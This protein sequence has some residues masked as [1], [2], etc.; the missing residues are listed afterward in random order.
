MDYEMCK[1]VKM[2]DRENKCERVSDAPAWA[3]H[4]DHQLAPDASV[5]IVAT[6]KSNAPHN[7]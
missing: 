7:V 4:K 6:L 3:S 1:K 2:N 5:S